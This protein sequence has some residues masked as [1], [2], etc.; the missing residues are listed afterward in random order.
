MLKIS[1]IIPYYN[2]SDTIKKTLD[3]LNAQTLL[4]DEVIFVDSGS[5]D[6]TSEI[7]RDYCNSENKFKIENYSPKLGT[8]SSS[9]NYGIKQ[10]KYEYIAYVDCGL[11]IPNKWLESQARKLLDSNAA[12]VS[13]SV[14][15][16]GINLIDKSFIANT[17]GYRNKTVCL[18]GSLISKSIFDDIGY[19]KENMRAGYDTDLIN[20]L[21]ARNYK[22]KINNEISLSYY[23]VNYAKNFEEGYKKVYQ[24]SLTG[25]KTSGDYKPHIY[26]IFFIIGVTALIYNKFLEFLFVYL[27]LRLIIVTKKAQDIKFISFYPVIML[28]SLVFDISRTF[29]YFASSKDILRKFK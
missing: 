2:E 29:G 4:P 15:T 16:E 27:I 12:L 8:P 10:S 3:C 7:I 28:T 11:N 24:Y 17:Y 22:R 6:K 1:V 9:I 13:C 21:K 19:L 18:P 5:T 14:K 26:T 20:R 23:G 25:W